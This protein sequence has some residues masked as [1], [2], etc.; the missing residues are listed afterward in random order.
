[1]KRR[2]LK[3]RKWDTMLKKYKYLLFCCVTAALVCTLS[4]SAFAAG[5]GDVAG[6]IEGTWNDAV[7]AQFVC[8]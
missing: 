1:M 2:F 6:A 4:A 3:L 8:P 5:T 7:A